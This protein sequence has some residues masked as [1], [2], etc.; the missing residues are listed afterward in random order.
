MTSLNI[1]GG[2]NWY[3]GILEID[4]P[5][6]LFGYLSGKG[7]GYTWSVNIA[8]AAMYLMGPYATFQMNNAVGST[9]APQVYLYA[10]GG[11][12]QYGFGTSADYGYG[13]FQAALK[14][15]IFWFSAAA[16]TTNTAQE[17][18]FTLYN[19]GN[20]PLLGLFSAGSA[21]VFGIDSGGAISGR[22]GFLNSM[23]VTTFSA[24]SGQAG[25]LT[26]GVF[27]AAS[28]QGN[29]HFP[30]P[31]VSG[32]IY[33]SCNS[34]SEA[35]FVWPPPTGMSG[36]RILQ[37]YGTRQGVN[38]SGGTTLYAI[39]NDGTLIP[40]Y[41]AVTTGVTNIAELLIL[42]Q[43]GGY[44]TSGVAPKYVE[45]WMVWVSGGSYYAAYSNCSL[46]AWAF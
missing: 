22:S 3:N 15:G 35:S 25:S 29:T 38:N 45:K 41:G 43:L 42:G 27:S 21:H 6:K 9:S 4:S 40:A 13:E 23:T 33:V 5:A 8:G 10:A 7:G 44:G 31:Y 14:W 36:F 19:A 18:V 12:P 11:Y 46:L 28:Y 17:G 26:V 34:L 37:F 1:T 16:G 24:T 32:G 2:W 30:C 20:Y 39:M